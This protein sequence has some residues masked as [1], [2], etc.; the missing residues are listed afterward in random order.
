MHFSFAKSKLNAKET[1]NLVIV[2]FQLCGFKIP[3]SL[4][5]FICRMAGI[6]NIITRETAVKKI[7][8]KDLLSNTHSSISIPMVREPTLFRRERIFCNSY[9]L[10]L[11]LLLIFCHMLLLASFYI[12]C[13][14]NLKLIMQLFRHYSFM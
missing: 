10:T 3:V 14:V 12:H 4:Q 1:K 9:H 6:L 2:L 8:D 7:Y 11:L 5:S 13:P